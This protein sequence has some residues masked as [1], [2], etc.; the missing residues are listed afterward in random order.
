MM[1][2]HVVEVFFVCESEKEQNTLSKI[3]CIY[4]KTKEKKKSNRNKTK[5]KSCTLNYNC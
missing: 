4:T 1:T 5:K 2:N 3:I